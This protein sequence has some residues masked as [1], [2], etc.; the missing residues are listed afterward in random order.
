M[1]L[2]VQDKTIMVSSS[3]RPGTTANKSILTPVMTLEGHEPYIVSSSCGGH[4]E[5]KDVSYIS[6]FPDGKQMISASRDKTIRRWDL[7]EGK[8]IKEAREVYEND[9]R[10]VGVSRDSR[11][12]VTAV[13]GMLKVCEVETG[14]IRIFHEDLQVWIKCIDISADSTPVA[15]GSIDGRALIWNLDTGKVVAGPLKCGDGYVC[16]LRLLDD[17]LA[18]MS[19]WGKRLQNQVWDIEAQKLNVSREESAANNGLPLP[20]CWTTKNKSIITVFSFTSGD[21]ATTIYELDASTLKAVGDSFKGHARVMTGLALSQLIMLFSL[22][23]LTTTP[24]SSGPTWIRPFILHFTEKRWL[25]TLSVT[26][27][28]PRQWVILLF[29]SPPALIPEAMPKTWTRLLYLP[30]KRWLCALSVTQIGSSH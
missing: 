7:R 26:Q 15:D 9:G 17:S 19:N 1:C 16:A 2:T 11:W 8:E 13:G 23:L 4:V 30:G 6:Y 29:Y 5:Y 20:V 14:I 18:V 24:S 28:G 12:V 3:K 27:I 10:A 25:C 22:V 21:T